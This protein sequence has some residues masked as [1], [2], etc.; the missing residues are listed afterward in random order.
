MRCRSAV[1]SVDS[2]LLRPLTAGLGGWR[3]TPWAAA[4]L[5]G[6]GRP[7]PTLPPTAPDEVI[8]QSAPDCAELYAACADSARFRQAAAV[9]TCQ[10]NLGANFWVAI[11]SGVACGVAAAKFAG[12]W[13]FAFGFFACAAGGNG[14]AIANF[15]KCKKAALL[16][17]HADLRG[18][19]SI[20]RNC[21]NENECAD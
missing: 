20:L 8:V 4:T 17:L 10:A 19:L 16:N 12:G 9:A 14:I 15:Y 13:G 7:P 2:R 18:C 11:G 1:R 5:I 21:C 6:L 3:S